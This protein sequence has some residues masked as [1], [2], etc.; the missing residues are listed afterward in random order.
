MSS[1]KHLHKQNL[2]SQFFQKATMKYTLY[3]NIALSGDMLLMVSIFYLTKYSW[4]SEHS[5]HRIMLYFFP[6]MNFVKHIH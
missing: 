5:G 6:V 2:R 4:E 1:N 3:I